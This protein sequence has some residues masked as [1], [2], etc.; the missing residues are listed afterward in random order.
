MIS[1]LKIVFKQ[2][3]SSWRHRTFD[4]VMD[5]GN[6]RFQT[7]LELGRAEAH[8]QVFGYVVNDKGF[9]T[10]TP[11]KANDGGAFAETEEYKEAHLKACEAYGDVCDQLLF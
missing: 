6:A 1:L 2:G 4:K 5:Y 7:G 9:L 11:S 3:W 8:G 10:K